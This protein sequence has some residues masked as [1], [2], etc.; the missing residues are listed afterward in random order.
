MVPGGDLGY[1]ELPAWEV[2][3]ALW[4]LPRAYRQTRPDYCGLRHSLAEPLELRWEAA[5]TYDESTLQVI[6]SAD[7]TD[8]GY[9]MLLMYPWDDGVWDFT[10][11][12]LSF[13]VPGSAQLTQTASRRTRFDVP[14]TEVSGGGFGG[15]NIT[16]RGDLQLVE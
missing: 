3:A 1:Q 8:E 2:P 12:A 9:P 11:E 10:P 16:W 14:G 13:F 7:I 5:A 4:T 6:L 15:S